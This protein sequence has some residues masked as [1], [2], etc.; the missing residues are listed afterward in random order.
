M[1]RHKIFQSGISPKVDKNL[2]FFFLRKSFGL[3]QDFWQREYV[4]L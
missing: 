4:S 2:P 1:K 3:P